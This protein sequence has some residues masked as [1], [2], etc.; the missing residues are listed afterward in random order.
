M[1]L[2]YSIGQIK[3]KLRGL[4]VVHPWSPIRP[5]L[6]DRGGQTFFGHNLLEIYFTFE[7]RHSWKNV[8]I[9]K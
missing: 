5:I 4:P 3:K 6:Y 1:I 7:D 2:K 8:F 9:I